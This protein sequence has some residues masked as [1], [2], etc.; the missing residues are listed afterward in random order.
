MSFD[1]EFEKVVLVEGGYSDNPFDSGGQ[2][3]FGITIA[4]ARANGYHG[5]MKDMPLATAKA[6]YRAQYW[7]INKLD[8]V[9]T[10]SSVIAHEMFDT[11]VNMGTGR[12]AL[13]LQRALSRLNRRGRDYPDVSIDGQ[14]GPMTI[15]ALSSFLAVRRRPTE[16]ES[17]LVELL[18]DQQGAHYLDLTEQEVQDKDEEFLYGWVLQRVVRR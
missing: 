9:S 4:V 18:N 3:M 17:V 6:I 13:F 7:D 15:S 2:T 8:E 12:A 11:G 14:V 1:A 10:I 16:S 5:E